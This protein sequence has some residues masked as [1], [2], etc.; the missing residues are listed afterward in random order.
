M[1]FRSPVIIPRASSGLIGLAVECIHDIA[2]VS[3]HL[4]IANPPQKGIAGCALLDD[5][6]I[7]VIDLDEILVMRNMRDGPKPY[8]EVIDVNVW[9]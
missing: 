8:P 2:F 7:N 6:I 5:L 4:H 9:H 1:L 3:K